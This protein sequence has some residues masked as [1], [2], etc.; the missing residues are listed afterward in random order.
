MHFDIFP[1]FRGGVRGALTSR[2]GD[3]NPFALLVAELDY[4]PG[5]GE[6]GV[7]EGDGEIQ[8]DEAMLVAA[9]EGPDPLAAVEGVPLLH[10]M[11]RAQMASD[12]RLTASWTTAAE[13][14]LVSKVHI[15]SL[16]SEAKQLHMDP[17]DVRHCRL[18]CAGMGSSSTVTSGRRWT[19]G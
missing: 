8:Q 2:G 16:A 6:E 10:L 5:G 4:E 3:P 15:G 1:V 18:L 12:D 17:K 13:H 9:E 11:L 7:D 14:Y 19:I